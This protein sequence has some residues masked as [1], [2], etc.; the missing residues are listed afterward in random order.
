MFQQTFVSIARG[1]VLLVAL[2]MAASGGVAAQSMPDASAHQSAGAALRKDPFVDPLDEAA[3]MHQSIT[4]RPLMSIARA[5]KRLVA[6]GMRGLIAVSDDDGK[7]WTQM[8][9][10]V[11]SDLLALSFPTGLEGWAVGHD[12]VVLHTADGGKRWVKQ[13]DG[14]MAAT[15]LIENYKTRIAAGDATLQPYLD[16]LVLNYKAGPSLP[17]LGVVFRDT[18]HGF[19]VGPFGMAIATDDGGKTW[20]PILERIDN[21]QFL[22][23][24][25]ICEV[26]GN[27]YIAAEKG[28]VFRLDADT[29]K[30]RRVETGYAGSFFG[31]VGYEDVLLAYGLRG[32]IYRSVDHGTTWRAMKSPLHGTVTSASYVPRLRTVAL[33]STAG[34]I[35]SAD[36]SANELRLSKSTRPTVITGV[37]A[38][39]GGTLV[40]SGLDGVSFAALR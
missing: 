7:T 16:Q 9:A 29:G 11:R 2:M 13:F 4:G 35:A 28:T 3:V 1:S 15:A 18:L 32:T 21:P 40:L 19:A 36:A 31:V 12:G 8:S 27:V 38:L 37:Q 23:L 5:G 10:P 25:A 14:R 22:H 24:D 33:V 6:V 34:E 17:L 39:A 30:F 20:A 26:A